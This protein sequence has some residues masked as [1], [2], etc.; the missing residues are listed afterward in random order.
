MIFLDTSYIYALSVPDDENDQRALQIAGHMD[1]K[2]ILSE[3]IFS[4]LITLIKIRGNKKIAKT[5]GIVI[6]NSEIEIFSSEKKIFWILWIL[7]KN[8]VS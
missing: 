2:T 1:E 3:Q 7:L 6:L 4:E 5:T 8:T